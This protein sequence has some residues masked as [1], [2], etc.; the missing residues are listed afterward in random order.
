VAALRAGGGTTPLATGLPRPTVQLRQV[1]EHNLLTGAN[2]VV[3]QADV[4]TL[5]ENGAPEASPH[6]C[7]TEPSSQLTTATGA[8]NCVCCTMPVAHSLAPVSSPPALD[9]AIDTACVSKS[10]NGAS[11]VDG[12][13]PPPPANCWVE[14]QEDRDEQRRLSALGMPWLPEFEEQ[15]LAHAKALCSQVCS[16]GRRDAG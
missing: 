5:A 12:D 10:Q 6:P 4:G 8:A 13:L 11:L 16:K 2:P 7:P 3:W 14:T 15:L 1:L 9:P